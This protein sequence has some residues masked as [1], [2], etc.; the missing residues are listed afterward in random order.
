[1]SCMLKS[2][3]TRLIVQRTLEL[4]KIRSEVVLRSLMAFV[5]ATLKT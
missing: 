4:F 5:V 1:M 2:S 3:S